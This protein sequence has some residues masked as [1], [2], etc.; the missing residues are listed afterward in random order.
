MLA[1]QILFYKGMDIRK[2][3]MVIIIIM[4]HLL[5]SYQTFANDY[6]QKGILQFE[7]QQYSEAIISFS[8]FIK[9]DTTN[10]TA[11]FNRGL[12][13]YQLNNLNNAIVD[14]AKALDIKPNDIIAKEKISNAFF[15]RAMIA[16]DK[17]EYEKALQDF[18]LYLQLNP[19]D[20]VVIF[21][22]G[23]IYSKQDDKNIA[24]NE[25]SK[26]ININP[27]TEYYF[28]RAI[29]YYFLKET[30]KSLADLNEVLMKLPKDTTALWLRAKIYYDKDNYDSAQKDLAILKQLQPNNA[31][32][33]DL[34]F[35]VSLTTFIDR[36]KYWG[37]LL[38]GLL[39]LSIFF[40]VKAIMKK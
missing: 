25:F 6:F 3:M 33:K 16:Y 17:K 29:D 32:V 20:D 12:C 5:C 21:N 31:A 4:L 38:L 2:A 37:L 14:F 22:R 13:Y 11:Y 30:D 24:I 26:A 34:Y 39:V 27:K 36:N 23:I 15:K 8:A 1:K 7:K 19:N 9:K 35:N 10:A 28:N 18:D 40:S